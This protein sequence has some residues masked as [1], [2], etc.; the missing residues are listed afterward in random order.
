MS[1]RKLVSYRFPT[2][3]I[4]A[5]K[6][7][8]AEEGINITD[9]VIRT[10]RQELAL[11][12]QV[13]PSNGW[14]DGKIPVAVLHPELPSLATLAVAVKQI[15]TRLDQM[16]ATLPLSEEH[17]T[18][19]VEEQVTNHATRMLNYTERS[20]DGLTQV[21]STALDRVTDLEAGHVLWQNR[22]GELRALHERIAAVE[23]YL[24][25]QHQ[26]ARGS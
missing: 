9:F 16:E 10:L 4:A 23:S 17:L 21:L 14:S 1:E 13:S 25:R 7:R 6:A 15:Q 8:G 5:L 12:P 2:D 3:L 18:E 26:S 20:L 11:P 22:V 24:V 19:M